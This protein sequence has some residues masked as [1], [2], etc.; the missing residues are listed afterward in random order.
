MLLHIRGIPFYPE[1]GEAW[2]V[3]NRR[4]EIQPS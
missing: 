3:F 2:A 1:K 4:K